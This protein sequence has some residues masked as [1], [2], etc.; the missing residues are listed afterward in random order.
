MRTKHPTEEL[1]ALVD[2]AL[3][4]GRAATV[5]H[6][7]EACAACR[8]ERDRLAA[9]V[10]ALRRIP[11]APEPSPFFAARLAARL[12]REERPRPASR[13]PARLGAWL[14]PS[15]LRWRLAAPVAA[16]ALAAGIVFFAIRL[17]RAEERAVAENLD[18]LLDYEA[19]ASLGDVNG[20][21][22]VAIVARL[23]EL[24]PKKEATP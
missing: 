22:D 24:V 18:L 13:W 14:D 8:A 6:H 1:T 15:A 2:G 3:P 17:Q 10:A 23:D 19:V 21:D 5:L 9:A 11:A 4:P 12:A 7:L 20:A 16:A